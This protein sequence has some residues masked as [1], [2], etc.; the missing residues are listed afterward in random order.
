MV[1]GTELANVAMVVLERR[2][3]TSGNATNNSLRAVC[4]HWRMA[5][6][7]SIGRGTSHAAEVVL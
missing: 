7:V 1:V 4:E 3:A 5:L 6:T 2:L